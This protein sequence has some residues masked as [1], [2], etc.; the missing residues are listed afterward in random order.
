MLSTEPGQIMMVAA[1]SV[2]VLGG[3]ACGYRGAFVNRYSLPY[4]DT[5]LRP[6]LIVKDFTDLC[7][8]LGC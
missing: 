3:R 8:R 6:D 1:H 7:E 4:E 2:D 5:T